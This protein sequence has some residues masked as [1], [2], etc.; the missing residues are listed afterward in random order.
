MPPLGFNAIRFPI[1][2]LALFVVLRARGRSLRLPLPSLLRIGVLGVVGHLIYQVLFIRGL[3]VTLAGNASVLLATTP[4]WTALFSAW[5]GHE[6][7]DARVWGAALASLVGIV[8]VALGGGTG[9]ALDRAALLGDLGLVLASVVWSAYTVGGRPLVARHGALPVTAWAL[10]LG[11]PPILLVGLPSLSGVSVTS[12]PLGFWLRAL[13][14]GALGLA[15]AYLIWYHAVRV[16]GS[17]RTALYSNVVPV[18]ALA[19]AW[20]WLGERPAPLQLA[21]AALILVSL[22]RVRA[23]RAGPR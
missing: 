13:Y 18:V 15:A 14:A 12:L 6:H 16:I 17:A 23:P 11:T 4:I 1:A 3:E 20:V 7:V 9:I 8:L 19:I 10:W 21:G 2:C 5:A 22:Q